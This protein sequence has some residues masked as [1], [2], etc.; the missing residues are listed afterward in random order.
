MNILFV[1]PNPPFP[2]TGGARL[3]VAH[4]ARSLGKQHTLYFVG[5]TG[6]ADLQAEMNELF[7]D[8]KLVARRNGSRARKWSRALFDDLPLWVRVEDSDLLRA[9][10]RAM[11]AKHAIDVVHLDM[12]QMALYA[13]VLAPLPVV[14][15]PHDSLTLLLEQ[16]MKHARMLPERL[17]A[18]LEF[19]KMKRFEATRYAF[20]QRVIVVTEREKDFLQI[21][22]PA[23]A[24]RVVANGVDANYFAPM[25]APALPNQI[26]FHGWI[27]YPENAAT[28]IEFVQKILP[29]IRQSIPDAKF[30]I[31]GKNP[32]PQVLA[33]EEQGRVHVTGTVDDLRPYLAAQSLMVVPMLMAGGIKNKV[34][35]AMAMGKPIV[36]T[37]EGADGIAARDGDEFVVARFGDEF[38]AA[39]VRLLNDAAERARLGANARAWALEHSWDQAAA[40]YLAVYQEA[41]DAAAVR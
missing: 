17:A 16:R 4:L 27:G 31:I 10:L 33:L 15:A 36:T 21:L 14:L 24:L 19:G 26:G 13:D 25:Q 6:E 40:Q 38:A 32:S 41:M 30:T 5:F 8:V 11:L 34:L 35:E 2:L 18:R 20:A 9:A 37:P 7:A 29:Q 28:V 23:L 12:G 39:C 3:I 22:A 1:A